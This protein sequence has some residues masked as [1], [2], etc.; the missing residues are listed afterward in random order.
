[1][2]PFAIEIHHGQPVYEQLLAAV[3]RALFTGQLLDGDA[4]P[5]VRALSQELRI[6]PTTAHKVVGLL[7]SEGVLVSRPGVGMVVTTSA[8]PS[9]DGRREMIG[10]TARKL[11]REARDLSLELGE[12]TETLAEA[13]RKIEGEAPSESN[14]P[15]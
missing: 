11:V 7:K 5:S 13:W 10:D 8:L 1:M 15:S 6:S 2:L 14:P 12:V 3:R 9:R 4:F